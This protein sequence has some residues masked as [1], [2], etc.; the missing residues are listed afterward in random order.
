[1]RRVLLILPVVFFAVLVVVLA[2][3]MLDTERGRDPS[4]I[5]LGSAE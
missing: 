1:M 4:V 2:F 5:P 3:L